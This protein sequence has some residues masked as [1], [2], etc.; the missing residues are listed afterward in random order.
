MADQGI[1][2]TGARQ[3]RPNSSPAGR[4]PIPPIRGRSNR[5]FGPALGL[6]L[7][8]WILAWPFLTLGFINHFDSIETA[9]IRG[10]CQRKDVALHRAAATGRPRLVIVGGSGALFGIDADLIGRKL[11]IPA[12]N[13]ATHAGLGPYLLRRAR[14]VLRPG[15]SALLCPEYELWWG[16]PGSSRTEWDYG[17]SYDKGFVWSRGTGAAL[18]EL[19]SVP[20]AEYW[21]SLSGWSSRLRGRAPEIPWYNLATMDAAGDLRT[22]VRRQTFSIPAEYAL[23]DP[24]NPA[25]AAEEFLE[26]GR[27]A[28]AHGVR[29]F[30]SWPNECRPDPPPT[31]AEGL[32]PEPLRA[33]IRECG[34]VLLNDPGEASFPQPW[35]TDT[36]YHLD[37]GG[38][39][40]RTEALIRRL[41]PYFGLP[42]AGE[43]LGGVYLVGS[44]TRWLRDENAFAERPDVRAMYLTPERVD[45]PDAITPAGLELLALRGVP[46]YCDDPA[47][48]SMLPPDRWDAREID[49]ER[50]SVAGWLKRYDRHVIFLARGAA[51]PSR[52]SPLGDE[53]P[54]DARLALEGPAPAAAVIGTGP[55]QSVRKTVSGVDKATVKSTPASLL[56][57]AAPPLTIDA[58]ARAGGSSIQADYHILVSDSGGEICVAAFEPEQSILVAAATFAGGAEKIVWSMKQLSPRPHSPAATGPAR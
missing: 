8:S 19:Y 37:G 6:T 16:Q 45:A 20:G 12:V 14:A 4:Y 40:V 42:P 9:W 7:G 57:R 21:D 1:D 34:F 36:R 55:W 26:F 18:R 2:G 5:R 15:D 54:A 52:A 24:G 38:R 51:R 50:G 32:T 3:T 53:F 41:R 48:Q 30:Y 10:M 17:I 31:A 47:V 43:A 33:F 56:G 35:F 49:R 44:H 13:D 46:V 22:A 25:C 39:R 27:W 29:V 58:T 28:K 11:N 23:P